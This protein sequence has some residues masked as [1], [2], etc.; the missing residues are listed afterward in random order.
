MDWDSRGGGRRRVS[1]AGNGVEAGT[2]ESVEGGSYV[3]KGRVW[4][5]TG[6]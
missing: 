4:L 5:N 2:G 6:E 1:L 3:C